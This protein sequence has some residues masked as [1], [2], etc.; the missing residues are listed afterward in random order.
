M[1][2]VLLTLLLNPYRCGQCLRRFFRFRN[3]WARR[4]V[5][6]TL[7]LLPL[8]ILAVWFLELRALQKVRALSV[9]EQN[10]SDQSKADTLS[11]RTV[12][13]LLDKR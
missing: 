13:Q 10:N 12:Q 2:W 6:L 9:S 11:P 1:D 7:C 3:R 4:M 8:V 5:S